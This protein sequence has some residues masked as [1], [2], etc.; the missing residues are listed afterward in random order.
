MQFIIKRDHK[1]QFKFAPLQS[2]PA[3][4]LL[5]LSKNKHSESVLYL[6]NDVLYERSTAALYIAKKLD[7]LWPLLFVFIIVPP[8]IRDAVYDWIAKNRYHWFGKKEN[9]M[10]PEA[11]VKDRFLG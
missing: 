9:C 6:K 7:G 8:F 4:K 10:V 11:G 5:Q 2:E 3:R 1:A